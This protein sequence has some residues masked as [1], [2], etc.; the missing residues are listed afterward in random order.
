MIAAIDTNILLD[1]LIPGAEHS[2]ESKGLLDKRH[3]D[4]RL[5]IGEIV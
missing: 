5:I 3:A 2:A 4:G 1:I